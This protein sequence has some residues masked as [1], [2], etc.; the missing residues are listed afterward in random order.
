M[1]DSPRFRGRRAESRK[2]GAWTTLARA[3]MRQ[4]GW[5]GYT[6]DISAAVWSL[7]RMKGFGA[8]A[9]VLTAGSFKLR[10]QGSASAPTREHSPGRSAESRAQLDERD[11]IIRLV[12]TISKPLWHRE[13]A[14]REVFRWKRV[15]ARQKVR[16]LLLEVAK[17][18]GKAL[19]FT[20]PTP[21]ERDESG[22]A[23]PDCAA[24]TRSAPS[25]AVSPRPSRRR[26]SSR[27]R[28]GGCTM[29]LP[30]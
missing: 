29:Y 27:T 20:S 12:S 19:A 15:P 3:Q 13:V 5:R 26:S 28:R 9:G 22:A 4:R 21:F 7:S 18:R 24:R 23:G 6:Y 8:K 14:L 17:A 11:K 2:R 30:P 1:G 25:R 16:S 10:R